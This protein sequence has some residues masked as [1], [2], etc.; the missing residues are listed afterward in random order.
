MPEQHP[1]PKIEPWP[2]H[3]E[4][5]TEQELAEI[6]QLV[7]G[8][9]E[10]RVLR[11]KHIRKVLG[12]FSIEELRV[13]SDRVVDLYFKANNKLRCEHGYD[14]GVTSSSIDPY[15]HALL[16]E[17]EERHNEPSASQCEV[18][19]LEN[20]AF[21]VVR[22]AS[23]ANSYSETFL[24]TVGLAQQLEFPPHLRQAPGK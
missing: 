19:F 23:I 21:Q 4:A 9:E 2:D 16:R 10:D 13:R 1:L 20:T 3:R 18:Q 12:A 11:Q 22:G 7:D 6:K 14:Y 15:A 24:S 8:S 17:L 5:P